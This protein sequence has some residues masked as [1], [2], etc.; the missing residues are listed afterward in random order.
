[1]TGSFVHL[2]NHSEYSLLDGASRVTDLIKAAKRHH[3]PAV[4]LTDHGNL[5]GAL[6]FYQ[7][8][9]KEDIK[10]I[11]GCEVYLTRGSRYDKS[12]G[13]QKQNYHHLVLLA[14]HNEGYRNLMYLVSQAYTEGFYYK[15]RV[16]KELLKERAE[17][18]FCLTA[19]LKGEIPHFLAEEQYDKAREALDEYLGIFGAENVFMEIME[20]G[21]PIQS[22]VNKGVIEL[23]REK[24][25]GLVATNDCH[26]VEPEDAEAHDI[27]LCIQTQKTVDD[28]NRMKYSS[29]EFYF[30][31]PEEMSRLFGYAPEA[32]AKTLAIAE[33]CNVEID[34]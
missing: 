19:C 3:M 32:I 6:P 29:N 25:V 17:G 12:A 10:P 4:A 14:K 5:F 28:P 16:D 13:G 33:Q 24:G 1:M 21:M 8:A 7:A 2:H 11:L 20:N 31:S 9:M 23:A 34:F 26:Y 30:K 27:L 15:P 22:K 18:L